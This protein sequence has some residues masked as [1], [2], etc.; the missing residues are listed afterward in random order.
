MPLQ[1]QVS[2]SILPIFLLT[3]FTDEHL[4]VDD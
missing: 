3:L 2:G 4:I 1:F